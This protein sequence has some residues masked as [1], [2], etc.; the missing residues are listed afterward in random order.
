MR[1][2]A[3]EP[4]AFHPAG[5]LGRSENDTPVDADIA[6]ELDRDPI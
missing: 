2:P 4:L 3:R 5:G 6:A 1:Q